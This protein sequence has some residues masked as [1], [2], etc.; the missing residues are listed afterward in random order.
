MGVGGL[1]EGGEVVGGGAAHGEDG[2][3][4]LGEGGGGLELVEEAVVA[5][6]DADAGLVEHVG[7]LFGAEQG[8]SGDGDAAG[9][10]D[11]EVGGDHH[12]G[13]GGAEED[14]SAGDEAELD[15]E[16]LGDAANTVVE[17]GVGP[18][19]GAVGDA[20]AVTVTGGDAGVEEFGDAVELLG[21]A[22]GGVVE[23]ENRPGFWIGE[24]VA[25]EGIGLGGRRYVVHWPLD[26]ARG[27]ACGT[28]RNASSL[29]YL[30]RASRGDRS[31]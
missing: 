31:A 20:G 10:D 27:A 23:Q 30:G 13:I 24:A 14:S 29:N 17:V 11:G 1:H 19:D 5:E 18:A 28:A 15:G 26:G 12:G 4:V 25:R 21:V 3:G 16:D 6:G 2:E 7:Q 8:H 22:V 9:F